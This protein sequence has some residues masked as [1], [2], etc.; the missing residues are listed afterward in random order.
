MEQPLIFTVVAVVLYIVTGKIL[1]LMEHRAGR[2]FEHRSI[3][4]F[5]LLLGL[6]LSSFALIQYGLAT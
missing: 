2:R 1:D 5:V 6:A 3:I 4:F